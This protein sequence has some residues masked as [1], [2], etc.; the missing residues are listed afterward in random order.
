MGRKQKEKKCNKCGETK[1]L[2][3]FYHNITKTDGHNG[4][5]KSCQRAVNL[6]NKGK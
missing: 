2:D 4:I 1:V 3:D 5:C 6:I